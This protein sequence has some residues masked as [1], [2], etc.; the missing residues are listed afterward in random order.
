MKFIKLTYKE[1]TYFINCNKIHII[2]KH[3]DTTWVNLGNEETEFKVDQTP[4]EIM[5][6]INGENK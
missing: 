3:G 6:L 1:A 5:E 2:S 4:E